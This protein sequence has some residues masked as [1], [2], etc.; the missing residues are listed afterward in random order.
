MENGSL[1]GSTKHIPRFKELEMKQAITHQP[2]HGG[3]Q[4][5]QSMPGYPHSQA[6]HYQQPG[7]QPATAPVMNPNMGHPLMMQQQYHSSSAF[8]SQQSSQSSHPNINIT[9][10][11]TVVTYQPSKDKEEKRAWSSD[12]CSCCA[13][14]STCCQVM[15]CPVC[16]VMCISHKTHEGWYMP[17]CVPMS[18]LALRVKIRTHQNI[19]GSICKDCCAV[20]CCTLC[21]ICQMKREQDT[22][23][24]YSTKIMVRRN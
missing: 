8:H 1:H 4:H 18:L 11:P 5:H 24:Q 22:C 7:C 6:Y 17:L 3:F 19:E 13:D 15:F 10:A 12:L 2:G 16:T 20:S 21:S 9:S 14:I 23:A